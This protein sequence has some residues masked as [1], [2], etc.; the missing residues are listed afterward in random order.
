[1]WLF[2]ASLER[3]FRWGGG[4]AVVFALVLNTPVGRRYQDHFEEVLSDARRWLF[5][6]LLPNTLAFLV[7][8]F[9]ELAA[10]VDRWLYTID[11]WFRFRPG[12]SKSSLVLKTVLA[13]AWFPVAYVVR[14]AFYL[15]IEPQV[16]PLKH[17]PVVTVSHKLLL[18]MIPSLHTSTGIAIEWIAGIIWCIPGIFGFVVW[19]LKEN[20]R[21]YA[22]NR[23]PRLKPV[24]IGHH[25]ETMRGLLRPGFH[26]GAI[27]AAFRKIRQA[28]RRAERKSHHPHTEKHRENLHHIEHA[29]EA[30]VRRELLALVHT[31]TGGRVAVPDH[32]HVSL[33][34]QRV[35]VEVSDPDPA[36]I[37]FVRSD[38]RI[39]GRLMRPGF[40][41]QISPEDRAVWD[42]AITGLMAMAAASDEP[43]EWAAWVRGW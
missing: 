34:A 18:P 12:Q 38:D 37:E 31:A 7:W 30:F 16:N 24:P 8:V 28:F 9:R 14:F 42:R 40:L 11:E 27:P 21:L 13:V 2:G 23:S 35:R 29:V 5:V 32:V 17:F 39:R 33:G 20:W 19:E 15:L 25:G 36:V 22:A 26:S 43:P 41:D 4:V 3:C 6:D 10:A 1:M